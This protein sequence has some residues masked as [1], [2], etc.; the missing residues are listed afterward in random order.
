MRTSKSLLLVLLLVPALVLFGC[1]PD[2]ETEPEPEPTPVGCGGW[3]GNTCSPSEYCGYEEGQSCGWADASATCEPKPE[4]CTAIYAP[5]C[6]CD[7]KTYANECQ[8]AAAGYGVLNGGPCEC[9]SNSVSADADEIVG[10]FT[11]NAVGWLVQWTFNGNGSFV[12]TDLSAPCPSDGACVW[13]GIVTNPGTW[14]TAG[15]QIELS[16][17][18]ANNQAGATAPDALDVRE[19]CDN[20][21]DIELVEDHVAVGEVPYNRI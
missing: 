20:P 12:K 2:E 6:G 4:I 10:N 15:T 17:D 1:P 13:S 21:G 14:T 16:Y 8:A 19:S 7:S 5:V 11:G 18:F 3:L 9:F